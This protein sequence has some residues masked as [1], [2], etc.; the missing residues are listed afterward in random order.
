[1]T[2]TRTPWR[3]S[4]QGQARSPPWKGV[5]SGNSSSQGCAEWTTSLPSQPVQTN[6]RGPPATT[7]GEV[8]GW[9]LEHI[10]IT[11]INPFIICCTHVPQR[12]ESERLQMMRQISCHGFKHRTAAET[13]QSVAA[14]MHKHAHVM[15]SYATHTHTHTPS[16]HTPVK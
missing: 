9:W 6:L 10:A 1:M 3:G 11:G 2:W 8:W 14:H 5:H 12:Y 7:A 4:T 13:V 16:M 15:H